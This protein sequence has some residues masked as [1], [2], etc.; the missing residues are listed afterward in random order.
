MVTGDVTGLLHSPLAAQVGG[1]AAELH[2][3]GA[4]LNEY[5]NA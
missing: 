5:Q 3:A 4:V 2:P 1:D